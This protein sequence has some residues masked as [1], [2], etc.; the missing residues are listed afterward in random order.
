MVE[1]LMFIFVGWDE[2]FCVFN[3]MV[4]NVDWLWLWLVGILVDVDGS[5]WDL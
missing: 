4:D 5:L 3:G 1:C 2:L